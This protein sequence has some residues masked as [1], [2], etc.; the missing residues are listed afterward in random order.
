MKTGGQHGPRAA[1]T[2]A[3]LALFTDALLYGL[4]VPV[5]PL[6]AGDQGAS[7]VGVGLLFAA[8]ARAGR[9]HADRR[10]GRRPS[11]HAQHHARRARRAGHRDAAARGRRRARFQALTLRR[12]HLPVRALSLSGMPFR[13]A[14]RFR[15]A[16]PT[17][18]PSRAGTTERA[19]ML[20]KGVWHVCG[21]AGLRSR[22]RCD[23]SLLLPSAQGC[24]WSLR[25]PPAAKARQPPPLLVR[26]SRQAAC[27]GA[28]RQRRTPVSRCTQLG[29]VAGAGP[30]WRPFPRSPMRT[31]RQTS[32]GTFH[33]SRRAAAS[34][35]S[36]APLRLTCS[37]AA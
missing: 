37:R 36:G 3:S 23:G 22:G 26:S 4:A 17:N 1:L 14:G 20:W 27:G 21:S 34:G 32:C 9:L 33:A 7:T 6:L 29:W 24:A 25:C 16:N 12:G 28:S 18:G 31:R 15:A 35:S 19:N 2:V 13:L 8:Y 30:W 11:R 10:P 5:L